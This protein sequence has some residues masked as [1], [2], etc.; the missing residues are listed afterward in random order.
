MITLAA[1][2]FSCKYGDGGYR[3]S[4]NFQ[5]GSYACIFKAFTIFIVST[6]R[7]ATVS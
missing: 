1:A 4:L 3:T 7:E 6:R 5:S 2:G